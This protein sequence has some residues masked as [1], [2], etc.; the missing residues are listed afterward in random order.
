MSKAK[1][2]IVE[3]EWITAEDIKERLQALGYTI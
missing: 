2:M 1:I 3:D